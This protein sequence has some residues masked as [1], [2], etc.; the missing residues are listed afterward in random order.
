MYGCS[1]SSKNDQLH[2]DAKAGTITV[3]SLWCEQG[4]LGTVLL[5]GTTALLLLLPRPSCPLHSSC[6][7][8]PPTS[9]P[10]GRGRR[11]VNPKT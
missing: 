1:T 2:F 6:M 3:D 4:L 11:R 8:R 9:T 5:M 10:R 7:P